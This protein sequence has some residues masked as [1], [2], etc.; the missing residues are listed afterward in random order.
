MAGEKSFRRRWDATFRR[1]RAASP[2]I[3]GDS[4]KQSSLPSENSRCAVALYRLATRRR[5][6]QRSYSRHD[7]GRRDAQKRCAAEKY[8]LTVDDAAICAADFSRGDI[9]ALVAPVRCMLIA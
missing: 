5:V 8:Y 4:D 1:R 3:R 7:A 2:A 9:D 6:K